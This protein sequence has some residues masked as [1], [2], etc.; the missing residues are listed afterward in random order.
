MR[1]Q[2]DCYFKLKSLFYTDVKQNNW[3]ER[4]FFSDEEMRSN[5]EN[6]S[7]SQ[8]SR[9][10][11]EVI[12]LISLPLPSPL[13]Q[14][15]ICSSATDMATSCCL[16]AVYITL[17]FFHLWELAL[18]WNFYLLIL[19]IIRSRLISHRQATDLTKYTSHREASLNMTV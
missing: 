6:T 10:K 16:G 15:F 9:K 3:P 17:R 5:K 14:W 4:E 13:K 19:W 2:S 7:D 12:H 8:G 1:N 18:D 11:E